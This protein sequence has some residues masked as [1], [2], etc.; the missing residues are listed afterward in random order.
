MKIIKKNAKRIFIINIIC[1]ICFSI[2]SLLSLNRSFANQYINILF[3]LILKPIF[4]EK[5]YIIL[6]LFL[7]MVFVSIF[8]TSLIVCLKIKLQKQQS[9]YKMI[10]FFLYYLFLSFLPLL[11]FFISYKISDNNVGTKKS[12]T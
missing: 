3:Q 5:K 10:I 2:L 12:S 6:V 4:R 7:L 11:F 9:S 8:F 1:I